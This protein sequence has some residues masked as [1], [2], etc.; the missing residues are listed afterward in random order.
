MD[1]NRHTMTHLFA[2]LG[3]PATPRAIDEFINS[4]GRLANG[5]ALDHAPFWNDAQ[6]GFLEEEMIGD[7]DWAGV[8]DELNSRLH[9]EGQ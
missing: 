9:Q 6:R 4:H 1:A 3:L 8:I 7:A 2:Q 5:L